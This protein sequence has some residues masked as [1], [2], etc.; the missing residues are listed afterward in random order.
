MKLY[1]VLKWAMLCCY[2][3][4]KE[5][6]IKQ[7]TAEQIT[8]IPATKR[9]NR[10]KVEDKRHGA[11]NWDDSYAIAQR[12]DKYMKASMASLVPLLSGTCLAVKKYFCV[13]NN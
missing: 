13:L 1:L 7:I 3:A 9:R 2:Q 10:E 11:C 4:I 5:E 6:S 8:T 12:D